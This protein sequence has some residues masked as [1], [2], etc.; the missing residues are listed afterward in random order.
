MADQAPS[1]AS[2]RDVLTECQSF[3]KH[4]EV[5]AEEQTAG[6]SGQGQPGSAGAAGPAGSRGEVYRQLARLADDL[7]RMEP[8]SPIPDLLR[9]AVK[10]GG[11]PF[12]ELIQELVSDSNALN[13]IRKRFGIKEAESPPA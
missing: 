13:D 3:L 8:H 9:W 5:P 1:L 10:L 4:L 2:V 6:A 12:R 7:S 11:M